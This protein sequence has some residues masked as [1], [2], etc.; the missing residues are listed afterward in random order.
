MLMTR[1]QVLQRFSLP[2]AASAAPAVRA[3]PFLSKPVTLVVSAA[4]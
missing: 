3:A 1:R 2:A 4:K